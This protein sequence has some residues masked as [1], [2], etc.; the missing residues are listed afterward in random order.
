MTTQR[1]EA[2]PERLRLFATIKDEDG[3]LA[4]SSVSSVL[5]AAADEIEQL[6]AQIDGSG[7]V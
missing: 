3:L 6:R 7:S 2:M 5:R 4:A 1:D